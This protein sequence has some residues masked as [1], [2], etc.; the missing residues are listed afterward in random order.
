MKRSARVHELLGSLPSGARPLEGKSVYMHAVKRR[1]SAVLTDL[2]T[3]LGGSV[4]AFLNRDVWCLVTGRREGQ[5]DPPPLSSMGGANPPPV[6]SMGGA[7]PS[8]GG[9]KSVTKEDGSLTPTQRRHPASPNLVAPLCGSRGRALLEKAM[10]NNERCHSNDV[11]SS[12]R[13]WGVRILHVDGILP[14]QSTLGRSE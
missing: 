14:V 12:A 6:S 5:K 13:S 8:M 7:K 2:I 1:H 11:L 9:A 4:E 10:H 3:Q